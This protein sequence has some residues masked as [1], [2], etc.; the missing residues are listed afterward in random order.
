[1]TGDRDVTGIFIEGLRET[2]DATKHPPIPGQALKTK[3]P[4]HLKYLYRVEKFC[5]RSLQKFEISA[6]NK[7]YHCR[8]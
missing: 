7:S 8:L 4:S 1:M 2:K 5:L 6:L 3:E